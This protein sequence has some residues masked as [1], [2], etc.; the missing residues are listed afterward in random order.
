MPDAATEARHGLLAQVLDWFA[1]R[2]RAADELG[3]LARGD[4]SGMAS[5]LGVTEADLREVLPRAADNTRLMDAMMRARGLDPDKLAHLSAALM[6]DLELTCTRCESITRC[7]RELAAGT[8]AARCHEFCG[9][10]E[11]LDALTEDRPA[12]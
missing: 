3:T 2:V 6:R 4:I 9:N 10:A 12:T 8:A 11:T 5:D 7:R 1:A